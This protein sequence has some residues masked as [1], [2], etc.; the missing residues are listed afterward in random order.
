MDVTVLDVA[1]PAA[2]KVKQAKKENAILYTV[3]TATSSL[4]RLSEIGQVVLLASKEFSA[5]TQTK[6]FER[7]SIL[8]M[9]QNQSTAGLPSHERIVV[10]KDRIDLERFNSG[11]RIHTEM[12]PL[13]LE[14]A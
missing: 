3:R 6:L 5:S 7:V 13:T 9:G 1:L 2:E 4:L 14:T 11:S 8:L 10:G 12:I